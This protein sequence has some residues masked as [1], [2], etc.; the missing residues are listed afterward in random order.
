MDRWIKSSYK[1]NG[2]MDA[3]MGRQLNGWKVKRI[4]G[5]MGKW[6]D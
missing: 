1:L 3:Q 6:K 4:N 5:Q 2:W